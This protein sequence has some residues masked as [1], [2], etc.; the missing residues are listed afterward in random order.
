MLVTISSEFLADWQPASED[1]FTGAENGTEDVR[2]IELM[3][4]MNE[5]P[6]VKVGKYG[7][8]RV[9][10]DDHEVELLKGEAKYRMEFW[11]LAYQDKEDID[12]RSHA[13]AKKL[14][15]KLGGVI[16]ESMAREMGIK[17]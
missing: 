6:K 1:I 15:L 12:R 3:D 2:W 13:L 17:I 16:T 4:K 5:A 8:I 10:L 14:Y 7:S 9:E 11:S